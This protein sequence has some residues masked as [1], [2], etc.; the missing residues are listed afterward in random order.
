MSETVSTKRAGSRRSSLIEAAG[1]AT[2]NARRPYV[3]RLCRGKYFTKHKL[4]TEQCQTPQ[5]QRQLYCKQARGPNKNKEKKERKKIT[6]KHKNTH[7]NMHRESVTHI[8]HYAIS[9]I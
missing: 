6:K 1:P 7:T 9:L 2:A 8:N 5:K 4:N 3:L